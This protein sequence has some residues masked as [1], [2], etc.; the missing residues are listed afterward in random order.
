MPCLVPWLLA[1]IAAHAVAPAVSATSVASV[2]F[3][4]AGASFLGNP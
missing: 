1:T 2:D 4:K 3:P